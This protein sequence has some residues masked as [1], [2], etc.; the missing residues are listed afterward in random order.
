MGDDRAVETD[1][2]LPL[3]DDALPPQILQV[4]L[5]LYPQGAVIPE[6]IDAPVDL[7]RLED[8]AAAGAQGDQILHAH[9]RR[10]IGVGD[11]RELSAASLRLA[12]GVG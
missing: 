8:E 12:C 2:V 10:R 6:A 3:P 7:A 11:H 9:R 4:V 5:E 1:H